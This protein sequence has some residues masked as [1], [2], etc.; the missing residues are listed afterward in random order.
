MA[1]ADGVRRA[2]TA[3]YAANQSYWTTFT[4]YGG[5]CAGLV[6]AAEALGFSADEVESIRTSWADVGVTCQGGGI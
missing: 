1:T 2:A 5:A 4:T 3:W 6:S